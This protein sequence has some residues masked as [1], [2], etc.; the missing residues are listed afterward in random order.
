MK[1]RIDKSAGEWAEGPDGKLNKPR[2]L[3]RFT[4][5]Q[6]G[7]HVLVM[8]TFIVLLVTGLPQEWPLARWSQ[9]I[10]LSLGGID[11]IREIHRTAGILLA[12]LLVCHLTVV[13]VGILRRKM[14]PEMIPSRKDF[15][16]AVVMARYC[17]GLSEDQPQYGR[18]DYRQKFEYWGLIF[19]SIIMVVSGFILYF[20][21]LATSFLPAQLV[22]AAKAA[23]GNEAILALLTIL[24]WHGYGAHLN[25]D[26]F[27]FDTSI[28]TGKIREDRMRHEHPL[29]YKAWL[30]R[31]SEE[32]PPS[33][34]PQG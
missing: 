1:R 3:P 30:A 5:W 13:T 9:T 14:K 34:R 32:P 22:P 16:D 11:A 4:A 28:F 25:P 21:T 20:P 19:G 15:R 31:N 7:E 12:V 23:H 18:F 27:P 29:E 8:V 10:I 33:D 17:L 24:V 26:V 6:R 2:M